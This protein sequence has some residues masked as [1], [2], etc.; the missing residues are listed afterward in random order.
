MRAFFLCL[1]LLL[2]LSAHAWWDEAWAARKKLSADP[3]AAGELADFPVLVRL[4]TG[5]FDFYSAKPDG[6]D[7]RFVAG[8][9]QTPLAFHVEKWDA[10]N[11]MALVWVRLP[12]LAGTTDFWLYWNNP[13][14][15]PVAD[16][17]ATYGPGTRLVYHFANDGPP[18]DATGNALNA[19]TSDAAAVS[20]SVIGP[21]LSFQGGQSVTTPPL[22]AGEGFSFSAWLRPDDKTPAAGTVFSQGALALALTAGRPVIRVDGR[23]AVEA[24]SPLAAGQ[25][26]HVAVTVSDHLRLY[27][28]GALSGEGDAAFQGAR[29][30]GAVTLGATAGGSFLTGG[31]DEVEIAT[32]ARAPGYLRALHASQGPEG[33][34]LS[35]GTQEGTD[36]AGADGAGEASYFKVILQS[37]TLDGWVV[38][39]IL[40]VM[41]LV[42]WVVMAMKALY[43]NRLDRA[44]R[45]FM[46]RFRALGADLTRLDRGGAGREDQSRGKDAAFASVGAAAVRA[47]PGHTTPGRKAR[48]AGEGIERAL[49][50]S[51]LYR[52]YHIGVEE[53]RRRFRQTGQSSDPGLANDLGLA[54]E[55]DSVGAVPGT[56]PAAIPVPGSPAGAPRLSAA[57]LDAIRATLDA[58]LTRETHRL[59]RLM[60]LLTIAI[61][62]GPFLGLLGTVVGVMITF[63]AIAA[64]GDVNVNAIAPGIA[65]AL[66]ATVAG[67]AVAIPALFG[68]NY[69]AS[70]I[71]TLTADMRVFVDEFVTR[72]AE[73]YGT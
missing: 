37:V 17:A 45:G 36:G 3:G 40:A 53:I 47:L 60:V 30:Q 10:L 2:P 55:R 49:Q 51:S 27:V 25:W 52:I 1:C 46:E 21:G 67:L 31:M 5:N 19:I 65:A 54:G 22:L 33:K 42:S 8:D 39:A 28:N 12:K 35:Y 73:T 44:N 7:L 61:S 43:I 64:S 56:S 58:G 72:V 38:I 34:F 9:D 59:D 63:A 4:H 16:A 71:K 62:G 70:R 32:L 20:T 15:A 68:Y 69:L 14:A 29:P 11:E 48:A 26:A 23:S 6:A 57:S 66:V 13:Q 24:A 50:D 18:A 41:A